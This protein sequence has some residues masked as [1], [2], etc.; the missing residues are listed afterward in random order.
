M[1][2]G[3]KRKSPAKPWEPSEFKGG[4]TL[5]HASVCC[6]K[7]A[8]IKD[9]AM[10]IAEG[11]LMLAL[12]VKCGLTGRD[13]LAAKFAANGISLVFLLLMTHLFP[14]GLKLIICQ[15]LEGLKRKRLGR[16]K[17]CFTDHRIH[18]QQLLGRI[19]TS[20]FP[21]KAFLN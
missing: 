16:D 21:S 17:F 9:K 3:A 1:T 12:H 8:Y 7:A 2:R 19:M 5:V 20:I 14:K 4:D 13:L 15:F 18:P 11:V 6:G 10:R